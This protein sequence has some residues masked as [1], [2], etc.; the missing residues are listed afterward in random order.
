MGNRNNIVY[1]S[2]HPDIPLPEPAIVEIGTPFTAAVPQKSSGWTFDG[3][4]TD[5]QYANK[6]VDGT[7]I[8]GDLALYGKWTADTVEVLV[9][10]AYTSNSEDTGATLPNGIEWPVN[11][12]IYPTNLPALPTPETQTT[13]I[14]G[15]YIDA[16]GEVLVDE[17]GVLVGAEGVTLYAKAV[18]SE[19]H[20]V[21]FDYALGRLDTET[22]NNY[23]MPENSGCAWD[24]E[25]LGDDSVLPTEIIT[26]EVGETV[27]LP[28]ATDMQNLFAGTECEAE[29]KGW[30]SEPVASGE[31]LTEVTIGEDTTVYALY[32]PK[33]EQEFVDVTYKIADVYIPTVV[34]GQVVPSDEKIEV[35]DA[36]SLMPDIP[37][38]FVG[39]SNANNDEV[40][41]ADYEWHDKVVKGSKYRLALPDNTTE[42]TQDY[43]FG[44]YYSD[45]NCENKIEPVI[46][47]L[48]ENMTVYL[49][50]VAKA[51][52]ALPTEELTDTY[53]ISFEVDG[54]AAD[55]D[56]P[57]G[58][59]MPPDMEL[60][61]ATK[62]EPVDVDEQAFPD[63]FEE[64]I[65]TEMPAAE[66][67]KF[68]RWYFYDADGNKVN[69]VPDET[70][71]TR[72]MV[73]HPE[74]EMVDLDTKTTVKLVE[75]TPDMPGAPENYDWD[76]VPVA[77][78]DGITNP[79]VV[80]IGSTFDVSAIELPE[81]EPTF[82][83][84]GYYTLDTSGATP[85]FVEFT[86]GRIDS[87][88]TLYVKF[89]S[90]IPAPIDVVY[91]NDES[92]PEAQLIAPDFDYEL[93]ASTTNTG[94]LDYEPRPAD[95][96]AV[97]SLANSS[98]AATPVISGYYSD[99]S[100]TNLFDPT[101]TTTAG[102]VVNIYPKV[103]T[104]DKIMV[105]VDYIP[106]VYTLTGSNFQFEIPT[107]PE[108]P[109]SVQTATTY[110]FDADTTGADILS[111]IGLPPVIEFWK[112][113]NHEY[114]NCYWYTVASDT[115]QIPHP[116]NPDGFALT[117]SITLYPQFDA[118]MS[119]P[120]IR[121]RDDLHLTLTNAVSSSAAAGVAS[122]TD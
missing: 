6:W 42:R 64:F 73:L 104:L 37:C 51:E 33:T 43:E 3:W 24:A 74:F 83:V 110:L 1:N 119:Y 13:T 11:T 39:E 70:E 21:S 23:P 97:A 38:E 89:A 54:F 78:F 10:F 114:G 55:T 94:G 31:P 98:N 72:D 68:V 8:T 53:N 111:T 96:V 91:H 20:S 108:L 87:A 99:A 66:G 48:N 16:Q 29:F 41:L 59:L 44:G 22:D 4:Y 113:K 80:D 77:P 101:A 92:T 49:K 47:E 120:P 52:V 46:D 30:Y 121:R 35:K 79:K 14:T 18:S 7:V 71:I 17:T 116:F 100:Y 106:E 5:M 107:A 67:F 26:G 88:T 95:L 90:T 50:F 109:L 27:A 56:V 85:V 15:W 57:S 19:V 60:P 103:E 45:V 36:L 93:A 76:D 34:Q 75:L 102:E 105:T 117:G 32:E 40:E 81:L 86:T 63:L 69:F 25:A 2:A 118:D 12:K 9:N 112:P 84:D 58:G 28:A 62:I 65:P 122:T 82:E 115:S 61:D